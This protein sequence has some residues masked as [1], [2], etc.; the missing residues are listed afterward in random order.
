MQ[1][2][3]NTKN[4]LDGFLLLLD[5]LLDGVILQLEGENS[6]VTVGDSVEAVGCLVRVEECQL[7]EHKIAERTDV[8]L[9]LQAGDD[10][11]VEVEDVD[12]GEGGFHKGVEGLVC[13]LI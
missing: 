11:V 12:A 6:T 3:C 2:Q 10:A 9:I 13:A 1:K 5:L 8:V 7:A 4:T